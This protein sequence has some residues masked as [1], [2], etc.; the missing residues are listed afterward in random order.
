LGL[1]E[2]TEKTAFLGARV[3][4]PDTPFSSPLHTTCAAPPEACGA[5][6]PRL[7][8]VCGTKA[9]GK[10]HARAPRRCLPAARRLDLNVPVG[11]KCGADEMVCL[12][13]NFGLK[14]FLGGVLGQCGWEEKKSSEGHISR[15]NDPVSTFG[16]HLPSGGSQTCTFFQR[17]LRKLTVKK[18]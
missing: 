13:V 3:R 10:S 1:E 6:N 11:A 14:P 4:H 7:G 15:K 9:V 12:L 17:T 18:K 8:V 5:A 16:N 2:A